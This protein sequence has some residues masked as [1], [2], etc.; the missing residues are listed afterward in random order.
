MDEIIQQQ[1]AAR[2]GQLMLNEIVMGVRLGAAVQRVQQ[3][4][5][6][7]MLSQQPDSPATPAEP[8]A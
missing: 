7:L 2:L 1:V 5:E 3:L 6:Q 8:E 4:E